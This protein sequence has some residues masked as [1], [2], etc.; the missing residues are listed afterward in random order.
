MRCRSARNGMQDLQQS[1]SRLLWLHGRTRCERCFRLL[2]DTRIIRKTPH[3]RLSSTLSVQWYMAYPGEEKRK[4]GR[5]REEERRKKRRR[6]E[7]ERR[8]GEEEKRKRGGEEKRKRGRGASSVE[9]RTSAV[10][11]VNRC[12]EPGVQVCS[13]VTKSIECNGLHQETSFLRRLRS[14]NGLKS[15]TLIVMPSQRHLAKSARD[16]RTSPPR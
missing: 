2:E 6:G 11:R 4:R 8:R 3:A 16:E 9:S 14:C 5:R 13:V 7:E 1:R 12:T 10:P 15:E